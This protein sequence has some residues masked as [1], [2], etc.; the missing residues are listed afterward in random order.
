LK[1]KESSRCKSRFKEEEYFNLKK[2][3][4][5]LSERSMKFKDKDKA[6]EAIILVEAKIWY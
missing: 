2:D 1:G 3:K 5:I 4:K 6:E